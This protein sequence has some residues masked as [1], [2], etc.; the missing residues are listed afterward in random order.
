MPII[1]SLRNFTPAYATV[2]LGT[3]VSWLTATPPK[4]RRTAASPK[5]ATARTSDTR[6]HAKP[7]L[8]D[9]RPPVATRRDKL[10]A[11]G[12]VLFGK[13]P[14]PSK[15]V[16]L[17]VLGSQ[18]PDLTNVESTRDERRELERTSADGLVAQAHDSDCAETLE[19][20]FATAAGAVTGAMGASFEHA[21]C[22]QSRCAL[23]FDH[24]GDASR[25]RVA[26]YCRPIGVVH[27]S[28]TFIAHGDEGKSI[29][30]VPR[31]GGDLFSDQRERN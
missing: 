10:I 20:E 1:V 23:H 27:D 15:A 18:G 2:G 31:R 8:I 13:H 12:R 30:Y 5:S 17:A 3:A 24:N 7:P 4:P 14:Q 9:P 19:R 21:D 29:V 6:T 26:P 25:R 16:P 11:S 22:E 28:K